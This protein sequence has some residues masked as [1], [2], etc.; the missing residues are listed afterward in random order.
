MDVPTH[1]YLF[2]PT[3]LFWPFSHYYFSGISWG[4]PWFLITNYS[5]LALT[6]WLLRKKEFLK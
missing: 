4:T 5:L 3:P 1:T 2:F 6:F